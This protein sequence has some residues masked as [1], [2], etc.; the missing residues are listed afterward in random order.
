MRENYNGGWIPMTASKSM[1]L[2]I[3]ATT[4]IILL[5]PLRPQ[6]VIPRSVPLTHLHWE[7]QGTLTRRNFLMSKAFKMTEKNGI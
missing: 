2:T 4:F 6:E 5:H 3:P 1:V 7:K